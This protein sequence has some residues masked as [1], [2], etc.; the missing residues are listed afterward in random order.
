MIKMSKF[1]EFNDKDLKTQKDIKVKISKPNW[2][3]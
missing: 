2:M 1:D 3:N